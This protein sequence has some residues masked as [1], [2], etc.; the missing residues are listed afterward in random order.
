M[1]N[2]YLCILN[3]LTPN[4]MNNEIE[5]LELQEILFNENNHQVL[6]LNEYR[7]N[8]EYIQANIFLIINNGKGM[9]LDPGGPKAYKHLLA[10]IGG[11]LGYNSLKYISLSHQDPDI[12]AGLGAWLMTT[13]AIAIAPVIWKHFIPHLGLGS[14]ANSRLKLV[15]DKGGLVK[16]E[17]AN[18][19]MLPAHFMHAVGNTHLYDEN[20]KIL[21]CGDLALSLGAPYIFV[22]NFEEHI[23]YIE[24]FHKRYIA[25]NKIVKQWVNMVRKLDVEIIA[26]QHGAIYKGKD[27]INELLNWLEN[28]ECGIDLM[29]YDEIEVINEEFL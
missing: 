1:I 10:D 6:L 20:S 12:L 21:F 29:N 18:I 28:Q 14:Y 17:N 2:Y 13:K 27:L 25:S 7:E 16:M 23:Q 8:E 11:F 26:P 22:T 4:Y 19:F 5:K 15:P 9:I 24:T 3:N